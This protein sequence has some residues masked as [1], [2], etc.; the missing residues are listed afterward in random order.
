VGQR[1]AKQKKFEE[2][3]LSLIPPLPEEDIGKKYTKSELIQDLDFMVNTMNDVHP[4]LYFSFNKDRADSLIEEIKQSLHDGYERIKFYTQVA[5]FVSKISDGHT[6]VGTHYEEYNK[7]RDAGGL[8]F[9]FDVDCSSGEISIIKSFTN[10][11]HSSHGK[12]ITSINSTPADVILDSMVSLFSFERREMTLAYLSPTFRKELFL[13]YGPSSTFSLTLRDNQDTEEANIAGVSHEVIKKCYHLDT[14]AEQVPYEFTIN[15]EENYALL[16]FR[17]FIDPVRFK[18]FIRDM[19]EQIEANS[20]KKLIVDIRKNGGG[21][22]SLTEEFSSYIT[23]RPF[24]QYS[25]VDFKISKQIREYYQNI[26]KYITPFPKSLLPAKLICR[27]PWEKGLGEIVYNE[28]KAKKYKPKQPFFTGR[29][30]LLT[31]AA[32]FSSASDF[33]AAIQDNALGLI[34]GT[35]TGGCPSSYGDNFYFS[36]PNTH[37]L[38]TVSHKYFVRANGN[39]ALEP[40]YPDYLIEEIDSNAEIDKVVEYAINMK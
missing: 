38:C 31:S 39:R 35:P 2:V 30:I 14:N 15:K 25:G 37:I 8:L 20:V 32:T 22:S 16:D 13:L 7:Y 27:K 4:D 9:P 24:R 1:K 28:I 3:I 23:C 29:I 11:Y 12:T 36:L 17:A 21:N 33:A 19:F 18:G 34:I 10:E 5:R 40:V 26:M 6:S